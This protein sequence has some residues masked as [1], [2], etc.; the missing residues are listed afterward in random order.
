MSIVSAMTLGVFLLRYTTAVGVAVIGFVLTALVVLALTLWPGA[1]L[2]CLAM[3]FALGLVQGAGFTI[4]PQLNT[5]E[6]D[7]AA[8]NGAMA[9]TGNLGN[10]LGTPVMLMIGAWAGYVGMMMLALLV[11]LA[12][13]LAHLG[14]ARLRARA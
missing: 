14:L 13:A 6:G 7:R 11:L 12:G 8:A 1:P 9:Q 2:L 4:V 10:T 3:V 5:A